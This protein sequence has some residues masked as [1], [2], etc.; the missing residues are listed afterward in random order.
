MIRFLIVFLLIFFSASLLTVLIERDA[1]FVLLSYDNH[2][3][4]TNIWF[5]ALLFLI[6]FL[7]LYVLIRVMLSAFRLFTKDGIGFADRSYK[8]SDLGEIEEGLLAF[9]ERDYSSALSYFIKVKTEGPLQ[10]VISLLGAKSAEKIGDT[11][12]QRI[13][14]GLAKK[15][16]KKVKKR[17]DLLEAQIALGRGDPDLAIESLTKIKGQTK[18]SIVIKI[19]A[20]L[21]A[22]R[23]QDV[24]KNLP[25]IEESKDRLFFENQAALI[26]LDQNK[27]KDKLLASIF[28]SLSKEVR[29]DPGIILAYIEALKEKLKGEAILISAIDSDFDVHLITCYYEVSKKDEESLNNL[30]RWETSQ[31]ENSLIPF[32]KGKIYE[33][34]GEDVLAEE[35]LTK[36]KDLGNPTASN[37]LVRFFVTRGNLKKARQEVSAL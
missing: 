19:K 27:K 20:L 36:S 14:L 23:W 22:K 26:A 21:E 15:K 28:S 32:L 8:K 3:F 10:G 33:A 4:R 2:F 7:V 31:P 5:F 37:E 35:F 6:T 9:F 24:F 12:L 17:A 18:L 1:G 13:F 11:D 29:E 25:L 16:N 34:R 30:T